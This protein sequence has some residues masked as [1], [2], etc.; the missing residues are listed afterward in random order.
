MIDINSSE[1][2]IENVIEQQGEII[3]CSSGFSM[4]PMLRNRK[5]MVVIVKPSKK[6]RLHDVVLY[7]TS[8]GKLLLHRIIKILENEYIIRA[9]NRFNKEYGVTE[10][11]VF[12]ILKG[13]YRNGKY[14][15]CEKSKLYKLYVLYNRI[16]LPF[17]FIW[18]K[19]GT[20]VVEKIKRMRKGEKLF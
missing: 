12:G 3:A 17:R 19:T 15:D 11:D 4:F 2:N 1:N 14:I 10:A 18:R 8:G 9:D 5:D 13:F 16:S 7:R 20:R 6:P